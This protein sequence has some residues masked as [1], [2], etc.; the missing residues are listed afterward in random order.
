MQKDWIRQMNG[1]FA[2]QGAGAIAKS[3]D[4]AM[5]AHPDSKHI[6]STFWRQL[7]LMS[8]HSSRAF[9]IETLTTLLPVTAK[10][11]GTDAIRDQ[12]RVVHECADW[13]K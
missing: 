5:T 3:I 4:E 8:A 1:F 10:L 13:W 12:I 9:L 11:F 6:A 2:S 7:V